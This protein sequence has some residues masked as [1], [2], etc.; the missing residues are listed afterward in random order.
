[1]IKQIKIE[2][3]VYDNF[4]EK[5]KDEE[6]NIHWNIPTDLE[7]FR[8]IAIDTINWQI[9][10]RV[11]KITKTNVNLSAS[12]AKA[13]ALIAKILNKENP[14]LTSGFTEL[15]QDSWNKIVALADNGY[16]DSEMLNLS[17]TSVIE[18]I[19]IGT[20]RIVAVTNASSLEE[21][22]NILNS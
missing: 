5:Y 19:N 4:E 8:A 7:E 11:K 1:M 15:E 20:T 16:A 9:G 21:V 17:L 3:L 13:I 18:N 6:G 2:E 10:D 12:N 22:I 14:D